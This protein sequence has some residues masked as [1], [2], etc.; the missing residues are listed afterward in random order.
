[1]LLQ[2]SFISDERLLLHNANDDRMT[3]TFAL[4]PV[5]SLLFA[6]LMSVGVNNEHFKWV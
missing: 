1:M 6:E 2:G 4:P 5:I 3:V